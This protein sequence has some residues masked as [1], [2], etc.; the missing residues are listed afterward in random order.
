MPAHEAV[1]QA[2]A[3]YAAFG[4]TVL[5]VDC[6]MAV[7]SEQFWLLP[8]KEY[9]AIGLCSLRRLF[10]TRRT[11]RSV[12]S[13]S[14][15]NSWMQA[16]TASNSSKADCDRYHQL[17]QHPL[18]VVVSSPQSL[19]GSSCIPNRTSGEHSR[20]HAAV[21]QF[22]LGSPSK[23]IVVLTALDSFWCPYLPECCRP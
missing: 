2:E 18:F 12:A 23:R 11:I 10:E 13:P 16:F 20:T 15:P 6:D 5:H 7:E 14:P 22:H 9:L 1:V 17:R 3:R 19:Y 4:E 8:F 21:V